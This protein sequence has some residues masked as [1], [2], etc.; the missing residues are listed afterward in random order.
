MKVSSPNIT[1][2][3][4]KHLVTYVVN[5]LAQSIVDG[6]RDD[7]K[8]KNWAERI[9]E[10]FTGYSGDEESAGEVIKNV[11]LGGNLVSNMNPIG[12]IPYLQDI[13]VL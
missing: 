10:A 3:I 2:P 9:L 13:L 1:R 6:L 8:D 11:T 7:D 5:A 4:R 12:R